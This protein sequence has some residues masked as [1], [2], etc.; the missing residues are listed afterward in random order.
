MS[1]YLIPNLLPPP[2][3]LPIGAWRL[4]GRGW[5]YY[6]NE[7]KGFCYMR[8]LTKVSPHLWLV[9]KRKSPDSPYESAFFHFSMM[10]DD[11]VKDYLPS[12]DHIFE[13]RLIPRSGTRTN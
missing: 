12:R 8:F 2:M 13:F 9:D 1:G 4:I 11:S 3:A 7:D 10:Q 5:C 6:Y